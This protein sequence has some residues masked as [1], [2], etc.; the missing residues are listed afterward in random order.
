MRSTRKGDLQPVFRLSLEDA[1]QM[2]LDQKDALLLRRISETGSITEAAK[3]AG[4]SYRS[5][6]DRVKAMESALGAKIVKT[7]VGGATGGEARLTVEGVALLQGFR[8]VRKYL[9]NALED[10]DYMA[11][12]GYKLSARNKLKAKITKVD[13]GPVTASVKMTVTLPAT[14]TSII[15]KEAAEDLD[16]REGDEVEAIIKSTEVM[17]GKVDRGSRKD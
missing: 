9:F 12:A 5:A 16:L 3:V 13:K 6:W 17:I 4:L 15:S 14:V 11:S 8:R 2:V 1:R 10:R 7:K